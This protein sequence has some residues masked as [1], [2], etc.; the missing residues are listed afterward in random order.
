MT[1]LKKQRI[2]TSNIDVPVAY[3]TDHIFLLSTLEEISIPKF[4]FS[5]PCV[6]L[7]QFYQVFILNNL[8]FDFVF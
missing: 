5:F 2:I 8:L 6:F 7:L 4:C 1:L 3:L